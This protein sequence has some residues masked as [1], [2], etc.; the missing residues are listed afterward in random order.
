MSRPAPQMAAPP[1]PPMPPSMMMDP[2][3]AQHPA[4]AYAMPPYMQAAAGYGP[5]PPS[6]LTNLDVM[7]A[8]HAAMMPPPAVP[9]RGH[10]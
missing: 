1:M 7:N 5:M 4:Y 3:Y 10:P 9:V 6:G 2:S 8:A